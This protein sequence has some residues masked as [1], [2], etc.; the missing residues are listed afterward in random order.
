LGKSKIQRFDG[1]TKCTRNLNV[2]TIVKMRVLLE[3]VHT[4]QEY[5]FS[6][7]KHLICAADK[8]TTSGL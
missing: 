8:N 1:M 3:E 6:A 2:F 5:Y 7:V 4:L